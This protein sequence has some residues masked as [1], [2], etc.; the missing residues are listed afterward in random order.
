MEVLPLTRQT[1]RMSAPDIS[2]AEIDAVLKVLN[3]NDL[4]MGGQIQAFEEE[5]ARIAGTKFAAGV[6]SG[7]AGLHLSV[8]AAGIGQGDLVVTTPFSFVASSNCLLYERAVPVFAGVD[9]Q[10]GK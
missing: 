10:T 6:S 1:I 7:T 5:M 4:S 3:S 2:Q 9:D 8:I